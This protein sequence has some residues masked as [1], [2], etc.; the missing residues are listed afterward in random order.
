MKI[1]IKRLND[2][3]HMEAKNSTGNTLQMDSSSLA[4]GHDLGLRPMELILSGMG[5]CSTIDILLILKKQRLQVDDIQIVVEGKRATD[6]VPAVFT[7]VH[8]HYKIIGNVPAEKAA[9]A[10]ALSLE[11]YCSVS[12]ML[13]HSVHITSSFEVIENQ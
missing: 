4:G 1:E 7:D 8:L 12:K 2:A 11:K 9:R 5:G 13:E 10:I 6:Q 3:F